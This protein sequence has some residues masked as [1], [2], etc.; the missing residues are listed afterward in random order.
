MALARAG[1]TATTSSAAGSRYGWLDVDSNLP[2]VRIVL[3]GPDANPLAAELLSRSDPAF[4]DALKSG[5]PLRLGARR[6]A[7]G[8]GVAAQRR[9]A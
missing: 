9:P 8:R 6:T 5:A 4:L 2:D 7:A 1:V 3:G